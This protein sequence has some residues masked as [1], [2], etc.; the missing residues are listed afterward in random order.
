M[1]FSSL[2]DPVE[3]G[4]IAGARQEKIFSLMAKLIDFPY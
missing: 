2:P 3:Y 4:L 1:V